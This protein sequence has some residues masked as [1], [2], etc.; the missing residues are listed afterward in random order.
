MPVKNG[1]TGKREGEK[2]KIDGDRDVESAEIG[3]EADDHV[4]GPTGFPDCSLCLSTQHN[5]VADEIVGLG[6]AVVEK[7]RRRVPLLRVPIKARPAAHVAKRDE[8]L[9]QRAA[10]PTT[11]QLPFDEKILEIA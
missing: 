3:S 10:D 6:E 2:Q 1:D 7:P 5:S 4:Q 9:D 8:V 11:A